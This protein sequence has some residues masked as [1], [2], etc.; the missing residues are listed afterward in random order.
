MKTTGFFCLMMKKENIIVNPEDTPNTPLT[1][2]SAN[3]ENNVKA[4]YPEQKI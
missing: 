4:I 2:I 3:F 1:K